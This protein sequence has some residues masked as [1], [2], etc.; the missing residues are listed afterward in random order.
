MVF[1]RQQIGTLGTTTST[2][3]S[4]AVVVLFVDV[5]N[6]GYCGTVFPLRL[7]LIQKNNIAFWKRIMV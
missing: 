7:R 2:G 1:P 5:E 6:E 4:T 3:T